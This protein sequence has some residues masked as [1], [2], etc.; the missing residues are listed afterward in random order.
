VNGITQDIWSWKWNDY[1]DAKGEPIK[2]RSLF[3][4]LDILLGE[5]E[6]GEHLVQFWH[7]PRE[8]D[9]EAD[10]LAKQAFKTPVRDPNMLELNGL[11]V[12]GY[13]GV[14]WAAR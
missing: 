5:L 12:V 8:Q 11:T 7:V 13:S 1:R 3:E 14:D 9:K 4:Y 2:H 10:K 6:E